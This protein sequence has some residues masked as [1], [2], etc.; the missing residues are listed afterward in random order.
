MPITEE[1][2]NY[3]LEQCDALHDLARCRELDPHRYYEYIE[4]I[5]GKVSELKEKL[6]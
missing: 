4:K 5:R 1:D 2:L 3:I 6:K